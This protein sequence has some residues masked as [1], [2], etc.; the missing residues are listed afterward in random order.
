ML[1]KSSSLA[2]L[3]AVLGLA[4]TVLGHPGE[5]IDA[6]EARWQAHV[7]HTVADLNG[8]AL[9]QCGDEVG[10][11]AR[12]ERAKQRRM[13]TFERLRTE[14]GLDNGMSPLTRSRR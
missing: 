13:A 7:R 11:V 8:R 5:K 10:I 2:V 3:T 14:K 6:L 9:G 12:K 4:S 1:A